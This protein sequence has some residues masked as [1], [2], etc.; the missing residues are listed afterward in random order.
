[1]VAN[2]A[3]KRIGLVGFDNVTASHLAGPA[4]A[5]A[6]AALDDGYGNSILCYEVWT[7]GL[8]A[9]SFKTESGSI[10]KPQSSLR[11]APE[12]D[13]IIIPGGS[14][15]RSPEINRAV[16]DWILKRAE[17]TRRFASICTGIYGLAPTGLL[18]GRE[19]TTHWRFASDV[20]RRFPDLRVNHKKQLIKD[21]DFYTSTGLTAGIDLSLMLIE[22]DYGPQVAS[23]LARDLVMYLARRNPEEEFMQPYYFQD[24]SRDRFAQL[25]S[26]I[27]RNLHE[28][29]SVEAL[30]RRACMCPRAFSRGFKSVFGTLP[31]K[32]VENL[33]LNEAKRRLSTSRNTLHSIAKSVGFKDTQSFRRSFEQRFGAKPTAPFGRSGSRG[34]M[35]GQMAPETLVIDRFR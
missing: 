21:G 16:A 2:L 17:T 7:V 13:T 23:S 8:T 35:T 4:D 34:A 6:A 19:V 10:L 15:L 12:F 14:G 22:E 33:R 29:L 30:A 11:A 9:A 28:D 3:P 27:V 20:A 32:F 1:M 5:F 24:Q 26:W 18:D 31:G 25:V